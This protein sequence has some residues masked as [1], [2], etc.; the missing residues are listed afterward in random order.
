[1]VYG[2]LNSGSYFAEGGF[3]THGDLF[4]AN[5]QG[6][7][8]VGRFG[9][10]TAVANNEQIVE[11]IASG[12]ASANATQN[13]LLRKQNELLRAILNKESGVSTAEIVNALDRSN[14]RNGR[15][16]VALGV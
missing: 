3:P 16:V 5:E 11:G 7:E 8:L 12:V 4:I 1:M 2:K 6:A 14:V 10:Q 13:E 9:N 15:T